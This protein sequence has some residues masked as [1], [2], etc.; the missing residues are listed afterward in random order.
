MG[1]RGI[2]RRQ[3]IM[4][5]EWANEIKMGARTG[6]GV[7]LRDVAKS[8]ASVLEAAEKMQSGAIWSR[9]ARETDNTGRNLKRPIK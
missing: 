2:P 5:F 8:R 1:E 6:W 9:V 4:C 3:T 7:R